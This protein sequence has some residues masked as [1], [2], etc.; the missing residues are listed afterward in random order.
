MRQSERS[1]VLSWFWCCW[2]FDVG[3][4]T[5]TSCSFCVQ[6]LQD[7]EELSAE[8]INELELE[9]EIKKKKKDKKDKDRSKSKKSSKQPKEKKFK[10]KKVIS[11]KKK[12]K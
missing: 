10:E 7:D 11:I 5:F 6:V 2:Y 1:E 12:P 3:N 8:L 4:G 9:A